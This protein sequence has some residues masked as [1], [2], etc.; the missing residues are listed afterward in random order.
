MRAKSILQ[1][2][3]TFLVVFF[4]YSSNPSHTAHRASINNQFKKENRFFALLGGGKAVG[5]LTTYNDYILFSVTDIEGEIISIGLAGKVWVREL[6][7]KS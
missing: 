4:L 5:A 7:L 3:I 1:T 2:I 6:G